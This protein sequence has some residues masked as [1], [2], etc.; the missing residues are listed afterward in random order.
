MTFQ[1]NAEG[2]TSRIIYDQFVEF[3]FPENYKAKGL[4]WFG[5]CYEKYGSKT[6]HLFL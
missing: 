2:L 3:T 4:K 6:I 5:D 1:L